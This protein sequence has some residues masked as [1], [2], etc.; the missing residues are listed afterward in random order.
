MRSLILL[1][2]LAL[3]GAFAPA[4]AQKALP[5]VVEGVHYRAIADGK[6]YAVLP[7][8]VVEVAE[9][10]HYTC[11]HCASFAPLLEKWKASLPA[12]AR[13]V[14][15]PAVFAE[16]DAYA[17]LFFASQVAKSQAVLHPRLFAAIHDAGS[18]PRNA[19]VGQLRAF[20]SSVPGANAKA[21]A[22]A[23]AD[24]KALRPKLR[25]A[26]EFAIRSD[27]PGTPSLVVAGRYLILGNSYQALLD[28]ARAVVGALAPAK[29]PLR[30]P[31]PVRPASAPARP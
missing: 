8:G 20:A 1:F 25:H 5:G 28:N 3:A 14:L 27:I 30:I 4:H 12:H 6:P 23:L 19:S 24:D 11:P 22:A 26:R 21:L 18:L 13:L 2:T 9:V 17:R 29:R 31:P 16:D 15:V 10:F 7:A